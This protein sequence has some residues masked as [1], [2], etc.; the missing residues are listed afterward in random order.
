MEKLSTKLTENIPTKTKDSYHRTDIFETM[1]GKSIPDNVILLSFDII[2]MFPSTDS[3]RRPLDS[4]PN[5]WSSTEYIIEALEMCLTNSISTFTGQNLIKTNGAA[6]GAPNSCFY[7][8]LAIQ[9]ID[10]AAID[11]QRTIA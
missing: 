8:D 3:D 1:N 2:N 5:L 9:P 7:S 10:N 11:A 4:I 6:M